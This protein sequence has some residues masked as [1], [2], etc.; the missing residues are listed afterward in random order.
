M[1]QLPPCTRWPQCS[2]KKRLKSGGIQITL[3]EVN[4]W[5]DENKNI[6]YTKVDR[7]NPSR[8]LVS[9]MMILANSLMAEFLKLNEMPAVFRSQAQPKQRI[10][11]GIETELMPNFMQRKQLSRAMI[12]THA[13]PHAGLGVPAYVTATSPIR[14]YHDLL[15]PASDQSRARVKQALFSSTA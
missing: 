4:V 8:M 6:H 15:T 2:G 14:R 12:T 5:L 1:I 13:E 3:P 10:F 7:E 9:E 11:K